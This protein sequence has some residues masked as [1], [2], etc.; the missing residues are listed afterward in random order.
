MSSYV[1]AGI[2]C[3]ADWRCLKVAG[4]LDFDLTGVLSA[5]LDPLAVAEISIFA[6]STY[7]T[8]YLLVK[9]DNLERAICAMRAAGHQVAETESSR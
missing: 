5:I 4:P 3:Q 7:D 9:S 2:Q 6:V 8:D 1:P